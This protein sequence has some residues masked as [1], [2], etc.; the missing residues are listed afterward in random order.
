MPFTVA[1][2]DEINNSYRGIAVPGVVLWLGLY[3][4]DPRVGGL[5]VSQAFPDATEYARQQVSW[6]PSA[7]GVLVNSNEIVFPMVQLSWGVPQF[8]GLSDANIGGS[9]KRVVYIRSPLITRT[10]T[11]GRIVRIPP[12]YIRLQTAAVAA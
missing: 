3:L 4:T 8:G 7:G 9:L 5:E 11:V 6:S 10:L 2:A 1:H 12:A